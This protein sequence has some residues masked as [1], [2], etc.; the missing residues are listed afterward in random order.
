MR[1]ARYFALSIGVCLAIIAAKLISRSTGLDFFDREYTWKTYL[2]IIGVSL[3][4]ALFG[5]FIYYLAV[6]VK[7]KA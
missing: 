2:V 6:R 4:G 3:I 1:T 5:N 7:R